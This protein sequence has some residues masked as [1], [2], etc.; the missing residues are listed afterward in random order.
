MKNTAQ[1]VLIGMAGLL[2]V[3]KEVDCCFWTKPKTDEA[4]KEEKKLVS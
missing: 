3:L 2:K 1:I 4:V